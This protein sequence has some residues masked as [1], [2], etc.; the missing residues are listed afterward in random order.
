MLN[1]IASIILASLLVPTGFNFLT[2][3]AVDYSYSGNNQESKAPQ[4]IL[5]KS[6]GLKTTAN[7]ILVVDDATGTVLY[8]KNSLPQAPIASITK[9]MTALVFLETNP[10]WEQVVAITKEDQEEGGLVRLL[11]GE[12]ATVKDLF[13][14]MLISST[15]EA[16]AALARLSGIEN[17]VSA[18]NS[19]AAELKMADTYFLGPSGVE[20]KN[21]PTPADLL[22][23]ADEAFGRPEIV[24]VLTTKAYQYQVINNQRID[25]A[26]NNDLLLDSFLNGADYQVIGAK[27]GY[28]DEA[29]YCLLLRVKK[30]DGPELTLVILGSKTID[31]RFQEAKGLVEW[32]IKNY[33]WENN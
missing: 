30:N 29:G 19:K 20:V 32:V 3:K 12:E 6:F 33:Q 22:K 24:Q 17:F 1:F 15:N 27:T 10:D 2:Q 5:N 4:R 25:K 11:P 16:A 8:N 23:L 26:F 7:S 18:M 21:V 31:D 9:L 14:L 28:L 13:N